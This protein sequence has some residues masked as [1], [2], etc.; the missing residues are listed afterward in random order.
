MD[1]PIIIKIGDDL[2]IN[3]N[4]IYSTQHII[5]KTENENFSLAVRQ[6]DTKINEEYNEY[7]AQRP[8]VTNVYNEDITPESPNYYDVVKEAVKYNHI[9][10]E[11][12]DKYIFTDK[13]VIIL[14][15]G[16]NISV[17]KTI[18]DNVNVV[19]DKF[20]YELTQL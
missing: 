6:L 1:N 20:V 5:E 2:R 18:Y 4:N 9:N 15:S 11:L 16:T 17:N 7:I 3:V 19:L 10:D 12:P 13:Y 14:N 8:I